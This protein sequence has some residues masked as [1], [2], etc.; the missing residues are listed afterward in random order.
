M[1]CPQ[2]GLV[3]FKSA[4]NC[5]RCNFG[6]QSQ[7]D[8]TDGRAE[9]WRDKNY[10]VLKTDS[11]LP[12]RC[13]MCNS[14]NDITHKSEKVGYFPKHNLLLLPLGFIHYKTRMVPVG[15][16]PQH[17]TRRK[18]NLVLMGILIVLG[19]A[20]FIG[21]FAIDFM[22]VMF[23]GFLT[24]AAGMIFGTVQGSFVAIEKLD[25]DCMWIKGPSREY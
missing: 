16:C 8:L 14:S 10:L 9:A 5:K 12:D 23:L 7:A 17:E 3:N 6:F 18:K 21:G 15:F 20:G 24:F 2:C 4:T 22:S 19:L 25:G 13:M 11:F 1:K